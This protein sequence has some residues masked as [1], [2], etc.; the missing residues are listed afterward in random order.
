ML[1]TFAPNYLVHKQS[2]GYQFSKYLPTDVMRTRKWSTR[3]DPQSRQQWTLFSIEICFALLDF[4]KWGRTD[5]RHLRKLWSLPSVTVTGRVD[6]NCSLIAFSNMEAFWTL[7]LSLVVLFRW[8]STVRIGLKYLPILC[9]RNVCSLSR[10][11]K[12]TN[13]YDVVRHL[14]SFNWF[15]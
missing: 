4:E 12:V 2:H 1:M 8:A 7:L 3:P 14:L 9:E 11:I 5:G 13:A 10:R 15:L 6:Q